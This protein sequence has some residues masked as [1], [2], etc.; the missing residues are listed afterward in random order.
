MSQMNTMP[1][2]KDRR[3]IMKFQGLFKKKNKKTFKEWLSFTQDNIKNGVELFNTNRDAV[4]KSVN[5]QLE[6][7]E[8]AMIKFWQDSGYSESEIEKLR[9]SYAM[10]TVKFDATQR[11]DSKAAKTL[12]KQ[13][14]T[15]KKERLND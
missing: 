12:N 9:E 1:K 2:R 6:K 11:E 10:S 14:N 4:E 15:L 5:E 8:L 13:A 3:S 7:K